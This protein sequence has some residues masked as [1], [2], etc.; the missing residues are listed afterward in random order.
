MGC[1][2]RRVPLAVRSSSAHGNFEV[3]DSQWEVATI[4]PTPS[5]G[6]GNQFPC[7][8]SPYTT[9]HKKMK[10][11]SII[12][13]GFAPDLSPLPHAA[14]LSQLKRHESNGH[15]SGTWCSWLSRSL[16]NAQMR[17]VLGSIP[18]VSTFNCLS[19]YYLLLW[20][21]LRLS[22]PERTQAQGSNS[23]FAT[24]DWLSMYRQLLWSW[25]ITSRGIIVPRIFW[26]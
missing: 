6:T 26:G 13:Q 16:S 14:A 15:P 3:L 18:N 8:L 25:S 23:I 17:E 20:I 19:F 10:Q 22:I 4:C 2:L 1:S 5:A 7:F 9:M 24:K 21:L 12:K 11:G